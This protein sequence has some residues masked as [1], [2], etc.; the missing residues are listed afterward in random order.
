MLKSTDGGYFF[1][2]PHHVT[3]YS[4]SLIVGGGLSLWNRNVT[5]A[6]LA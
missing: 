6:F 2:L 3:H 1:L 5:L 4:F